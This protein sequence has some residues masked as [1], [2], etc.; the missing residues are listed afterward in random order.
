MAAGLTQQALADKVELSRSSVANIEGGRQQF[1]LHMLVLLA[2]AVETSP[3]NLLPSKELVARANVPD[4]TALI[5]GLDDESK[6]WVLRV[7]AP[8]EEAKEAAG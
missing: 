3:A 7:L 8:L 5:E 1:P 2:S 4:D 6:K